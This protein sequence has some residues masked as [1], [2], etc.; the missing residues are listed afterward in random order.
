MSKKFPLLALSAIL[1]A[2]GSDSSPPPVVPDPPTPE[3]PPPVVVEPSMKYFNKCEHPRTGSPDGFLP[4]PD[5]PGTL[6]DEKRFIR[7]YQ[8]ENYLWYRE[9]PKLNE[10]SYTNVIDYF[11]DLKTT[12]VTASGAP[13]DRFHFTYPSEQWDAMQKG[14]N[15]GYGMSWSRNA[16]G[17]PPRTW[18][19]SYVVPGTPAALAGMQ[20]GDQLLEVD[21]IDFVNAGTTEA[22]AKL[23]AAITPA[24]AGEQHTMR[25]LRGAQTLDFTLISATMNVSPVLQSQVLDT[26]GGKVGYLVF[27]SHNLVAEKALIDA[28]TQF[29]QEQV[30]ELVLDLRYNGGGLLSIASELA[31]MIAGPAV[32]EGKVFEQTL[33]NDKFPP[34]TPFLFQSKSYGYAG[35]PRN[36]PL[37]YLALPRV[38]VLAGP[39]TCSAS[40]SIVNGLRGIDFKVDLVGGQTCGKPYAFTPAPNCGTTYFSIQYQGVNQKGWGDYSDGFAPTCAATDDFGHALGDRSEGQLAAALG[41]IASGACPAPAAARMRSAAPAP[42]MVPVRP[43]VTELKILR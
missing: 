13:K 20:R 42:Q 36:Q 30:K 33:A 18:R 37:P 40:E 7:L 31:Y 15:L 5:M 14:A 27:N 9:L 29:R 21:G 6:A 2:C 8:D 23:N 43:E 39:G 3:P 22:V 26:P 16:D 10:A 25:V 32:T 1:A 28:F 24:K 4:Y 38:V 34:P 12:A 19:V 11:N 17:K 41:L 35:A